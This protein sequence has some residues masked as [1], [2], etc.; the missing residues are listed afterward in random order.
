MSLHHLLLRAASLLAAPSRPKGVARTG[1]IFVPPGMVTFVIN[2]FLDQFP[3]DTIN[4]NLLPGFNP[5][6]RTVKD[7]SNDLHD[8][9]FMLTTTDDPNAYGALHRPQGRYAGTGHII[10][11]FVEGKAVSKTWFKSYMTRILTHEIAHAVDPYVW[12]R[13]D[14]KGPVD[15]KKKFGSYLNSPVEVTA[16]LA[17]VVE[18]LN[19]DVARRALRLD[20]DD[21]AFDTPV[22][23]WAEQASW[24]W[25]EIKDNLKPSVR[26]RFLRAIATIYQN[27]RD[28]KRKEMKASAAEG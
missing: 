5:V 26:K 6:H 11:S 13:S 3:E 1:G 21:P 20:E 28:E 25:V 8:I 9:T 15:G 18:Q 24:R 23:Y 27:V 7:A 22:D 10:V 2:K 14:R 19:S 16:H 12:R 4:S 17:E